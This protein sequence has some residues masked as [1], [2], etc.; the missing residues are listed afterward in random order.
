MKNL[1]LFALILCVTSVMAQD[2]SLD[3]QKLLS[4]YFG[5]WI[6]G[7]A[8]L[9]TKPMD[10]KTIKIDVMP[11][12]DSLACE[13]HVYQKQEGTWKLILFEMITYDRI[14]NRIV[15]LGAKDNGE[16]F[17]GEGYFVS[18]TQWKMKDL[19]FHNTLYLNAE[20]NFVNKDE[21][22]LQGTKFGKVLWSTR[23]FR[24]TK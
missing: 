8:A 13:I 19:D 5:S 20:F 7:D 22:V 21:V 15:A 9:V 10:D 17:K 3:Q 2:P 11:K 23:V 16:V 1:C 12:L 14:V 6:G 4:Q 24:N 18:P